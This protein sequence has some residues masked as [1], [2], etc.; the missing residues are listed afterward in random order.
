MEKI[1]INKLYIYILQTTFKGSVTA[2]TEDYMV[3]KYR[4][5]KNEINFMDSR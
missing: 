5:K 2:F 4:G 1:N 3:I